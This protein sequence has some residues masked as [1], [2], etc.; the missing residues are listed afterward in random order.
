M[1]LRRPASP[2]RRL[3]GD[4]ESC[5]NTLLGGYHDGPI[6]HRFASG[7]VTDNAGCTASYSTAGPDLAVTLGNGRSCS[8]KAVPYV[9]GEPIPVGGAISTLAV[10][11]PDG[12]G[13]TDDGQ[14]VV[15]TNRGLLT[16]C[17][18][19]QPKPFGSG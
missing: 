5:G 8:G 19:G 15:R 17:R 14:L 18:K 7:S 4:Y 6:T 12:F 2:D 1:T 10:L 16:M 13:F 11:R 9:A 3:A